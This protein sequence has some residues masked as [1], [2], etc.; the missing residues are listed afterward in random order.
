MLELFSDFMSR[1]IRKYDVSKAQCDQPFD[2]KGLGSFLTWFHNRVATPKFWWE[3]WVG[4]T[5]LGHIVKS[6]VWHVGCS[7]GLTDAAGAICRRYDCKHRLGQMVGMHGCQW[8]WR[9]GSYRVCST[10]ESWSI[11]A[12]KRGHALKEKGVIMWKWTCRQ[13]PQFL[14]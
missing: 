12:W 2:L 6:Q 11:A 14:G 4:H 8:A 13:I 9:V 10:E 3:M 1:S 5:E 7:G